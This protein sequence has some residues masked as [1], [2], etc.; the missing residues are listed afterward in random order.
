MRVHPAAEHRFT[1][2]R[3]TGPMVEGDPR[4]GTDTG[5][6]AGCREACCKAAHAR[7]RKIERGLGGRPLVSAV[8]THRRLEALMCLGWSFAEQSRRARRSRSWALKIHRHTQIQVESALI[9]AA[10]YD[11]LCNTPSPAPT[12]RRTAAEAGNRGYVAPH[13]WL[14]ID[15]PTEVPDPG[16]S[17]RRRFADSDEFDEV[18]VDRILAGD[19]RLRATT[20]EKVEVLRRW[21]TTGG[22]DNALELLTGWKISRDVRPHLP[23]EESAA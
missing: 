5:Y 7:Q 22:T 18:V 13:R 3:Q 14:N 21:A 12:A 17:P 20:V 16:W 19:W 8:G 4:H 10:L 6:A 15:D 9:V 11:E 23:R 2:V 1:R